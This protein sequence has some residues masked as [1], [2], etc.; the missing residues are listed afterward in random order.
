M[1]RKAAADRANMAQVTLGVGIASFFL[2]LTLRRLRREHKERH[3]CSA[4]ARALMGKEFPEHIRVHIAR[5]GDPEYICLAIA[6]N[7]LTVSCVS[8]VQIVLSGCLLR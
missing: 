3:R 1:A 6:E 2:A 7:K 5:L 4:R 8:S